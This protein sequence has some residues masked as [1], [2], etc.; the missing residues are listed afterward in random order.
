MGGSRVLGA[1]RPEGVYHI[2]RADGR[3]SP[4]IRVVCAIR[5][6]TTRPQGVSSRGQPGRRWGA[7]YHG[8][9]LMT[10]D[11]RA[12][13]IERAA[14]RLRGHIGSPLDSSRLKKVCGRFIED[15]ESW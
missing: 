4:A 2:T 8:I 9:G 12:A 5:P 1:G 7:Q 13:Q 15:L 11:V 6:S 14:A 10:D 3:E